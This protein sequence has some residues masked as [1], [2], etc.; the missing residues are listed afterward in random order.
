MKLALVILVFV[1]LVLLAVILAVVTLAN[2]ETVPPR[3]LTRTRM[4][5]IEKRIRDYAAMH[6]R[7]PE[8]LSDL[9]KPPKNRDD[10]LV[11]GWGRAI[12]YTKAGRTVTLLS[13]GE[14][15]RP[16]GRNEDADV[17]AKF[18]VAE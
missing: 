10:S 6:H 17:S 1:V 4:I 2:V 18:T 7:L 3:A 9:P 11:D 5:V 12:Q 8:S 16:G 14:D 15:G 13:F